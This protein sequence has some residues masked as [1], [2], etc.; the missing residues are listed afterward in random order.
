MKSSILITGATGVMGR[1]L[2][3][4]LYA[5]SS[6]DLV[7]L[8]HKSG[9]DENH[10]TFLRKYYGLS[11][12]RRLRVIQGD[13]TR[14][15]LGLALSD[16]RELQKSLTH[17]LHTAADTRFSQGIEQA[18]IVNLNGTRHVA[19]FAS[20]CRS[21]RQFGHVS[22]AYV[23]G[24]RKGQI[25]ESELVHDLG[26]LNTYEQ[27]KYEAECFVRSIANFLPVSVFRP[28]IIL[29]NSR[30]GAVNKMAAPHQTMRLMYDGVA[31]V[32]PGTPEYPINF[33]PNDYA[34]TTIC[35]LFLTQFR[36]GCTYHITAS[37]EKTITL[38]DFIH[39]VFDAFAT[40]DPKWTLRNIVEPVIAPEKK[41]GQFSNPTESRDGSKVPGVL[42]SIRQLDYPKM[43][44]RCNVTNA[45]PEYDYELPDPREYLK[46]VVRF[47][48][49]TQWGRLL[50]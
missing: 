24:K 50:A 20:A 33:I 16:R 23:S 1:E 27:S 36:P 7:L 5:R 48:V 17:I 15:D 19:E 31:Q 8:V 46:K 26:F 6:A 35:Q 9:A 44:D 38:S 12:C 43:F 28:S 40:T 11:P 34:A 42:K 49:A 2:V 32:L 22:T 29:G 25:R 3:P 45:I 4:A 47:C 14:S 10:S 30:T 13:V 41:V 37:E 39:E 18:R 21:L